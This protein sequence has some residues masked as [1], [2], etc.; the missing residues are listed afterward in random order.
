MYSV[1]PIVQF[2]EQKR[3]RVLN[4]YFITDGEI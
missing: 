1:Q 4:L 3:N 2:N